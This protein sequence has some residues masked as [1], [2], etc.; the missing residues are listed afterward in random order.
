MSAVV[1]VTTASRTYERRSA[2]G[3]HE[4]QE[5][6]TGPARPVHA[7]SRVSHR[8]S[9]LHRVGFPSD[10]VRIHPGWFQDTLPKAQSELGPIALL[11]LDGDFYESTR[12]ALES[13]YQLVVPGGV[14]VIDDYGHFPGCREATNEFL[15]A[16]DPMVYLH[17][18]DYTGRYVIK[19]LQCH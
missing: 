7:S 6:A 3:A 8:E 13:L 9:L 17:H 11:R 16:N 5:Q 14:V 18:V 4:H 15:A 19:A 10:R 2:Y 1:Q 12:V